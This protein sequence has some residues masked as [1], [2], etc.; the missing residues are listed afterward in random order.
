MPPNPHQSPD[1]QRPKLNPAF[2]AAAV[3]ILLAVAWFGGFF[4]KVDP[5]RSAISIVAGMFALFVLGRII[6]PQR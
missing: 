6:P 5:T 3:P 4:G 2:V 1:E